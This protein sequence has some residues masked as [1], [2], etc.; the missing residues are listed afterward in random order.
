MMKKNTEIKKENP[1]NISYENYLNTNACTECTGLIP[2]AA[3]DGDEWEA[4][5]EIFDFSAR[6]PKS[7]KRRS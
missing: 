2:H 6:S 1:Y 4:Y 5:H 3:E 7:E